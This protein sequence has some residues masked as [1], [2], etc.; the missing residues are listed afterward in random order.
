ML[1]RLRRMQPSGW[2]VPEHVRG[3]L[4]TETP[5][6]PPC[7]TASCEKPAVVRRPRFR[8]RTRGREGIAPQDAPKTPVE[9]G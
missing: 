2:A 9:A 5:R 7:A 3:E 8:S 1:D 6:S 4:E